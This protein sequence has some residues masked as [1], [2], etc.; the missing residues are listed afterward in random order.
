M[1]RRSR[2][3]VAKRSRRSTRRMVGKLEEGRFFSIGPH[4][5]SP[6]PCP[7]YPFV[8]RFTID[9]DKEFFDVDDIFKY[10]KANFLNI[11][12][13]TAK[14]P[15]L[16]FR[17]LSVRTWCRTASTAINLRTYPFITNWG[18]GGKAVTQAE[19][20]PAWTRT[21]FP[22]LIQY[23]RLG[24]RWPKAHQEVIFYDDNQELRNYPIAYIGA[25]TSTALHVLVFLNI[26]WSFNNADAF[27]QPVEL[28]A[29]RGG[30]SKRLFSRG[31]YHGLDDFHHL[32]MPTD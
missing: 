13:A 27:E 6:T 31:D 18:F 20:S 25:E 4:P 22:A 3:R 28:T 26:L 1:V 10:I 5:T 11:T 7:W 30:I 14:V 15:S 21:G 8:V 16:C 12:D 23:A 17:V 32:E 2:R 9:K 19:A 24:F 29:L